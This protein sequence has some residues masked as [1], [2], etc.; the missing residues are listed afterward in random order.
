MAMATSSQRE[1]TK[2]AVK[3]RTARATTAVRARR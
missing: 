2:W 3:L 1:N